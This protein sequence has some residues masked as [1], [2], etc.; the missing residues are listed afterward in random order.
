MVKF[1]ESSHEYIDVT[2]GSKW[3]GVTSWIHSF[4]KPKDWDKIAERY[5]KKHKMKKEEVQ[6][7]WK[8]ENDKAIIRGHKYHALREKELIELES[9]NGLPIHCSSFCEGEHN[10]IFKIAPN[11]KLAPGVYPELFVALKSKK[12]CGQADY[13]EITEDGFIKIKDFKTNKEIKMNGFKDWEGIEECL[14]QPFGKLPDSNFWHYAI[15]LNTYM[16]IIRRN[17]PFLKLGSMELLHIKFDE[18][19]E[20]YDVVVHEIPDLQHLI[21]LALDKKR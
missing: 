15:Q 20:Q 16:Y 18:N 11:Q 2:D 17:N 4:Q 12:I 1:I 7:M 3:Q 13:V 9:L 21:K 19:D 10:E 14:L 5:A 6:A 8:A